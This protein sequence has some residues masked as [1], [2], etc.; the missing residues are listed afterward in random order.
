MP[1]HRT[2]R[3]VA[4]AF[5]EAEAA[6]AVFRRLHEQFARQSTPP[7]DRTLQ[8]IWLAAMGDTIRRA[9]ELVRETRQR[10][11]DRQLEPQ[12]VRVVLQ[13]VPSLFETLAMDWWKRVT[14]DA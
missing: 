2:L 6:I 5:K 10:W 3:R 14:G 7:N 1:R 11:S 8:Q 12:E 4:A 9:D 13:Q